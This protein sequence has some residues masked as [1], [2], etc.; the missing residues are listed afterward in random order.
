MTAQFNDRCLYG[1]L[2][3]TTAMKFF[4][5]LG[6]STI[7]AIVTFELFKFRKAIFIMIIPLAVVI[8]T[9]IAISKNCSKMLWPIIGISFFHAY[10]AANGL[11]IFM[12]YFTFKPLYIIMVYN[13]A[14]NTM[15]GGKT[16]IWQ[17]KVTLRFMNYIQIINGSL[18]NQEPIKKCVQ[19]SGTQVLTIPV[20]CSNSSF[21]SN[22]IERTIM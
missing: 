3:I 14:F 11:L 15:H 17:V 12:F 18:Q 4:V 8:S 5:A 7:A 16:L 13:W 22:N 21:I 1:K 19:E 2:H 6:L 10:L 9:I 20:N